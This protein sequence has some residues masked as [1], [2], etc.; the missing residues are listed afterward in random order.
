MYFS[1]SIRRATADGVVTYQITIVCEGFQFVILVAGQGRFPAANLIGGIL[2]L[3]ITKLIH[4]VHHAIAVPAFALI[5]QTGEHVVAVSQTVFL[6]LRV[7]TGV[8]PYLARHSLY[9]RIV[10]IPVIAIDMNK[11]ACNQFLPVGDQDVFDVLLCIDEGGTKRLTH[12]NTVFL[13]QFVGTVIL[14]EQSQHA[15]LAEGEV[16]GVAYVC[17]AIL[18]MKLTILIAIRHLFGR[19][20]FFA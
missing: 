2:Y 13:I 16:C 5:I 9:L 11:L 3:V 8:I 12:R 6:V 10:L 15:C 1:L 20:C 17:V 18:R 14:L 7:V 19:G 4:A